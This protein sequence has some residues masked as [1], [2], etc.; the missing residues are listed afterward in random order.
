MNYRDIMEN[1]DSNFGLATEKD[2]LI[3]RTHS[4]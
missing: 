1:P 3:Y 2:G 4:N